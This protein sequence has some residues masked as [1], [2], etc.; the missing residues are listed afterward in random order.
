MAIRSTRS[1]HFI[2]EE[3]DQV[4]AFWY[5][6]LS[7]LNGLNFLD[8][9]APMGAGKLSPPFL[10]YMASG[11]HQWV[12]VK[13]LVE[14]R[15]D[16][17]IFNIDIKIAKFTSFFY[18]LIDLFS[19]W[20][21]ME[22][23]RGSS[24]RA[25]RRKPSL[26]TTLFNFERVNGLIYRDEE[27]TISPAVS[28]DKLYTDLLPDDAF[29]LPKRPSTAIV[30]HETVRPRRTRNN[31]PE[32]LP[33][34]LYIGFHRRL[35]RE[36]TVMTNADIL[37]LLLEIDR[38]KDHLRILRSLDWARHLPTITVVNNRSDSNEMNY[39]RKLTIG[40]IERLIANYDLWCRRQDRLR[41]ENRRLDTHEDP[42][43]DED[44]FSISIEQLRERRGKQKTSK[45]PHLI[46]NLRNG[47]AIISEPSKFPRIAPINDDIHLSYDKEHNIA[48]GSPIPSIRQRDYSLAR[49]LRSR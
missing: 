6:E 11:G 23:G 46:L 9:G 29:V 27:I 22:G 35:K 21:V 2:F 26:T 45:L 33:D 40:E 8:S 42:S 28:S 34:D 4:N 37:R 20:R 38:L 41:A 39:K 36:E 30:V 25:S 5:L 24:S 43:D 12:V 15:R 1:L 49:K 47:Y 44:V 32:P 17:S 48:F 31:L 18:T 19:V 14:I 10:R 13:C 3:P 7:I 16:K